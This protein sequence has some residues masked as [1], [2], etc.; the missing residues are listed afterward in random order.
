MT[1]ALAMLQATNGRACNQWLQT[2]LPNA[3]VRRQALARKRGPGS[4]TRD[5]E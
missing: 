3:A 1:A 4:G 2:G 5:H